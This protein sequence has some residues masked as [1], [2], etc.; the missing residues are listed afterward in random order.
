MIQVPAEPDADVVGYRPEVVILLVDDRLV[1]PVREKKTARRYRWQLSPALAV[2]GYL[3]LQNKLRS[4][5]VFFACLLVNDLAAI[6][7][8]N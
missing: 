3:Q 8:Y 2:A 6:P 1:R 4:P 5:V 7:T